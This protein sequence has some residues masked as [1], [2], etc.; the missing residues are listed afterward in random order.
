[1]ANSMKSFTSDIESRLEKAYK[2]G[3]SKKFGFEEI[4][5]TTVIT[6]EQEILKQMQKDGKIK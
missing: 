4:T 1:M 6:P 2:G 5:S 3:A